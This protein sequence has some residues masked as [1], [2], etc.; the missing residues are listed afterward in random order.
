MATTEL[1]LS[2]VMGIPHT[3]SAKTEA[4]E[5]EAAPET[6]YQLTYQYQ[7]ITIVSDGEN[8]HIIGES[9]GVWE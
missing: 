7:Y 3:F 8:Y 6:R 5:E 9:T 4:E 1:H 2:G